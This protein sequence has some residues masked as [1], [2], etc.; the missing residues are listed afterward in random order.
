MVGT[1]LRGQWTPISLMERGGGGGGGE[2][3]SEVLACKGIAR[4]N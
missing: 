4:P 3:I 1:V 2:G